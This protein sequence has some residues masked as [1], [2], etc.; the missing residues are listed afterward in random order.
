MKISAEDFFG[1]AEYGRTAS[2]KWTLRPRWRRIFFALSV[3]CAVAYLVLALFL[4]LRER[5]L[6]EL[7][8]TEF[9]DMLAYPFSE[10]IRRMQHKRYSNVLIEC[11]KHSKDPYK[12]LNLVKQGLMQ[13]STQPDGRIFY[14]YVLFLQRRSRDALEFLRE[15]LENERELT[16][17]EYVRFFTRQCAAHFEDSLLIEAA[18]TFAGHEKISPQNR[19]VLCAGAAQAEIATRRFADAEK[20]LN[21]AP[22]AGT[23]SAE[24]LSARMARER[25]DVRAA[26]EILLKLRKRVD[27]PEPDI[28]LAEDLHSLGKDKIALRFLDSARTR[29]KDSP[30]MLVRIIDVLAKIDL[31]SARERKSEA[32]KDFFKRYGNSPE[33]LEQFAMFAAN[34]SEAESVELCFRKAKKE[35]FINL[36]EFILIH[37]ET[38]LRCGAA[39]KAKAELDEIFR[40]KPG[41]FSEKKTILSGI[42]AVALYASGNE[43]LGQI[44]LHAA[45]TSAELSVS[46]TVALA[47][48]LEDSGHAGTALRFLEARKEIEPKNPVLL[49][50]VLE[51]AVRQKDSAT[52]V[53]YAPQLAESRRVSRKRLMEFLNF[54]ESDHLVFYEEQNELSDFFKSML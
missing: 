5:N 47:R 42:R 24:F 49:C 37:L 15:G 51:H 44:F 8:E 2:G 35:V 45:R 38:L 50:A 26:A 13:D 14:S 23:S 16:H 3:L 46:Q 20:R 17:P 54:A 27:S 41:W 33:A 32:E 25:G 39:E 19:F 30:A 11:A 6:R 9:S 1:F 52:F 36:P 43:K 53:R 18:N 40:E 31:A 22:L 4:F 48:M 28:E 21:T 12:T 7:E 10:N 34:R 29:A